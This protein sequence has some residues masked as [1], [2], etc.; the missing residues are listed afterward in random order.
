MLLF[1]G[2]NDKVIPI[3]YSEYLRKSITSFKY[4][5]IENCGHNPHWEK[6]AEFN[7]NVNL[8]LMPEQF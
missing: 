1:W 5:E 8:F 6:S 3:K 2:R 4:Y 7:Q